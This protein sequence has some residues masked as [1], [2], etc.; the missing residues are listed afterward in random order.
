MPIAFEGMQKERQLVIDNYHKIC[1]VIHQSM[2]IDSHAAEST[3]PI[4]D[5]WEG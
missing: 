4:K 1:E 5:P 2:D 3:L